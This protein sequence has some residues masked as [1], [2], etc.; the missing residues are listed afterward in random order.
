MKDSFTAYDT[1]VHQENSDDRRY[2]LLM[3]ERL[4]IN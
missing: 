4:L 1:N 2:T 3:S